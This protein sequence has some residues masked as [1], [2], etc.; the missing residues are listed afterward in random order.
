[1]RAALGICG[2]ALLAG[3]GSFSGFQPATPEGYDG[4][5][6]NVADQS[7]LQGDSL[8]HV[9]EMTAVD[10]RR[11]LST[12]IATLQAHQGRGFSAAPVALS[13][14]LP[15]RPAVVR[16]QAVTQ[17]AAPLLA[18][19]G[20]GCRVSGDLA[21]TPEAGKAYRVAGRIAPDACEAWIED[22]A[23]RQP[24]TGKVSGPGTGP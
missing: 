24:V 12:S 15:P 6:V 3:C 11:L 9:F 5:T 16:L 23:T 8:A 20:H 13:N 18:M 1:M 14:E 17:Y 4:P 22:R 2:V 21:F 7:T 10:G 19:R